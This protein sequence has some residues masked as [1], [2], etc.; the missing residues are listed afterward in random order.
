[1]ERVKQKYIAMSPNITSDR[2]DG[3]I[4]A[5]LSTRHSLEDTTVLRYYLYAISLSY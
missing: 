1:M 3:K 4:R 2:E 5:F